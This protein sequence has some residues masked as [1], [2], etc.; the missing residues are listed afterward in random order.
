[1]AEYTY[2]EFMMRFALHFPPFQNEEGVS[3]WK[4]KV[5]KNAILY[6]SRMMV[7]LMTMN[8]WVLSSVNR[9]SI[10]AILSLMAMFDTT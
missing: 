4:M 8:L 5:K 2:A 1:M 7:M 3:H 6:S 9:R 10:S